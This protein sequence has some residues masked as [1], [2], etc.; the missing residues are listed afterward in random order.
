MFTRNDTPQPKS[1]LDSLV[2]Q[3]KENHLE[4]LRE[5]GKMGSNIANLLNLMTESIKGN[6]SEIVTIN[7]SISTPFYSNG[8]RFNSLFISDTAAADNATLQ[9][10]Y[11]GIT[12]TKKL[13]SGENISNIPEGA[14]Y[15]ITSDSKSN[16]QIII[17]RTNTNKA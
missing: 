13:T 9:V 16:Y 3:H 11:D 10:T 12:F 4:L 2:K 17:Q 7:P 6:Q 8:Y 15:T 1:E 14:T 5:F